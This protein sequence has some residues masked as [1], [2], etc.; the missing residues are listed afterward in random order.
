[1]FHNGKT[2]QEPGCKFVTDF[3]LSGYAKTNRYVMSHLQQAEP[4]QGI[5]RPFIP[6]P[7]IAEIIKVCKSINLRCVP[8]KPNDVA[9]GTWPDLVDIKVEVL[10]LPQDLHLDLYHC[11]LW[12]TK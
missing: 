8:W 2:Y 1:M 7:R 9:I 12:R 11:F 4:V 5:G 6:H 3:F 10:E